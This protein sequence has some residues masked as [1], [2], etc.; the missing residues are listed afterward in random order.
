[1]T[2]RYEDIYDMFKEKQVDVYFPG[3]KTGEC[4]SPYVVIKSAGGN[5]YANYSSRVDYYDLLCYVP[6]NEYSK[7]IP[8]KNKIKGYMKELYPMFID[9]GYESP[10]FLDGEIKAHMI[11][12]QYRNNRKL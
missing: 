4:L 9:T 11:N 12:V 2:E 10:S 8:F 7:L 5:N 6:S 3:Q 1:M